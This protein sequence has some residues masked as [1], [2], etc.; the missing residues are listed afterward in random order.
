MRQQAGGATA[1]VLRQVPARGGRGG[2]GG[3]DAKPCL[4]GET[5]VGMATQ[6]GKGTSPH[7]PAH[8]SSAM[9]LAACR[10]CSTT[11]TGSHSCFSHPPGNREGT[12]CHG[13]GV[14]LFW[15]F[16]T[17]TLRSRVRPVNALGAS[18]IHAGRA[19]KRRPASR[20]APL[21][22]HCCCS[23][24]SDLPPRPPLQTLA[25]A[26]LACELHE[27]A[28]GPAPQPKQQALLEAVQNVLPWQ[29]QLTGSSRLL[30]HA[31]RLQDYSQGMD[32]I[33]FPSN[34]LPG[35]H[36]PVKHL[37]IDQHFK[38][39]RD[40]ALVPAQA[41]KQQLHPAGFGP[42]FRVQHRSN[43]LAPCLEGRGAGTAAWA[44]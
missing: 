41:V 7:P 4:A 2:R 10:P 12:R 33:H 18:R 32:A 31:T 19:R 9:G 40:H 11:Q 23:C 24:F 16:C 25:A 6:R 14:C 3:C 5:P 13:K 36:T 17:R 34:H 42:G 27:L 20:W 28:D 39:A 43:M 1:A 22:L 21:R 44:T 26:S 8:T 29:V 38:Q 15:S 30:L 37:V 35:N